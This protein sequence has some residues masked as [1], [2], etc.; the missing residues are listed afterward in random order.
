[1]NQFSEGREPKLKAF[2]SLA[3]RRIVVSEI[4]HQPGKLRMK[5]PTVRVRTIGTVLVEMVHKNGFLEQQK[6]SE[7]SPRS[8]SSFPLPTREVSL[9]L[10]IR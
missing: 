8:H 10:G 3:D 2:P 1:M 6:S 9:G 4:Y 7:R 5:L